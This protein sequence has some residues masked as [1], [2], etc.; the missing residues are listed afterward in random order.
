MGKSLRGINP[1]SKPIGS[2]CGACLKAGGWWLHLRRCAQCGYIGC[3]DSSPGQHAARH[4]S[5]A[6]HPIVASF[7]PLQSW[8]YDY[9]NR[10]VIRGPRLASPRWHP[11]TQPAPGPEGK[12]PPNWES[13]LH[14][15]A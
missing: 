2:G 7:E 3:C 10:K 1:D 13:L 9:E 8:F 5:L 11:E 12:V 4:A 14:E 6:G 15:V